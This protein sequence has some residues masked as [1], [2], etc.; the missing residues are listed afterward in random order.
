VIEFAMG[1]NG[2]DSSR[3]ARIDV[4]EHTAKLLKDLMKTHRE[5][6]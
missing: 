4:H 5:K 2:G 1:R 3:G 6:K